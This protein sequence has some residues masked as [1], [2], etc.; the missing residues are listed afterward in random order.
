MGKIKEP[1]WEII[2][3]ILLTIMVCSFVFVLNSYLTY[4]DKI[5]ECN[6][7]EDY[8]YYT[9]IQEGLFKSFIYIKPICLIQMENGKW[10][11]LNDIKRSPLLMDNVRRR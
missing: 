5:Q 6:D 2:I 8:G 9:K 3:M 10:V 1:S 7:Y 4:D 11:T